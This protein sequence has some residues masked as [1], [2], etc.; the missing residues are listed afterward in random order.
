VG[1]PLVSELESCKVRKDA[2][3]TAAK[4]GGSII[5]FDLHRKGGSS[6]TAAV[7]L[8]LTVI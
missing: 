2:F 8:C 7:I 1:G 5:S 6:L 3:G 4:V